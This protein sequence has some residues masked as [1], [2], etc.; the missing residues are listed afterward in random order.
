MHTQFPQN[1]SAERDFPIGHPSAVDFDPKSPEAAAWRKAHAN[2][3]GERDFPIGH[4]GAADNPDRVE[5]SKPEETAR[6]FS[7]PQTI[8][9]DEYEAVTGR[10]HAEDVAACEQR[11]REE[12]ERKEASRLALQ[13]VA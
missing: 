8:P 4:P 3:K 2:V 1:V 11:D 13:N 10:S 7:R 9:K 12:Y 6:D 5:P